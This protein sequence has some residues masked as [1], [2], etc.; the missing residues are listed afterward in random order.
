MVVLLLSVAL[1][2]REEGSAVLGVTLAPLVGLNLRLQNPDQWP[3]YELAG[4]Y[5][6]RHNY[7]W[8]TL[9]FGHVG[10]FFGDELVYDPQ[11]GGMGTWSPRLG[12]D[13]WL[14]LVADPIAFRWR[15][16]DGHLRPRAALRVG[17]GREFSLDAD[18][19]EFYLGMDTL[20]VG[21]SLSVALD[22][23]Q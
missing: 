21:L 5:Q 16:A 18:E 20:Y 3:Y 9:M 23:I 12:R 22:P 10:G 17:A 15:P 8:A 11:V 7:A 19:R 2:A 6:I 13:P 1:G 4:G 14:S